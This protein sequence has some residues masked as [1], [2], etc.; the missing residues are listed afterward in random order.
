M[1]ARVPGPVL[2]AAGC[3][4][5]GRELEAYSGPDGLDGLDLVT[6]S[7]TLD[8][9]QG[10]PGPRLV[11]VPGGL[12]NAVGLPNPGLEHF[13]AT[14]LPW[15]VAQGATVVVSM[16]GATMG[17]YADL[18]RRLGRAPGLAAVE[19]NLSAPDALGGGV[20]DVRE[21]FQAAGVV[22]A[23]RR[24]LPRDVPVIAKLRT[25]VFRVVETARIV[26]EAGADAVVIGNALPAALPD[27][28]PGGLSGPAV[29]PLALRCVADVHAALPDLPVVAAGGIATATDARAFL[30]A[31]A[32]AVQV[33]TALLHDPTTAERLVT[34]L[35]LVPTLEGAA[36]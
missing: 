30:A 28:R 13:L 9:R 31:G 8:A 20:F 26:A 22:S 4:G 34:S 36:P 7:I 32:G 33:G 10:G 35:E 14:E 2:V 21:P 25:D 15:L 11:E 24:D 6:R 3:G 17:E 12:V 5:T 19:V 27:G 16:A 18:A 23:V 1:S 29:R